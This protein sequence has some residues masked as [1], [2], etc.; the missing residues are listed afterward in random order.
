MSSNENKYINLLNKDDTSGNILFKFK[1]GKFELSKHNNNNTHD[2]SGVGLDISSNIKIYDLSFNIDDVNTDISGKIQFH[3]FKDINTTNITL[4]PSNIIELSGVKVVDIFD[5][6]DKKKGFRLGVDLSNISIKNI[7]DSSN[8]QKLTLDYSSNITNVSH[9]KELSFVV[10]KYIDPPS[11][12]QHGTTGIKFYT[13]KQFPFDGVDGSG[14]VF[15][16]SNEYIE[17]HDISYQLQNINTTNKICRAVSNTE[18]HICDISLNINKPGRT[19]SYT[20]KIPQNDI[21]E[22]GVYDISNIRSTLISKLQSYRKLDKEIYFENTFSSSP[23]SHSSIDLSLNITAYTAKTDI[24]NTNTIMNIHLHNDTTTKNFKRE[25]NHISLKQLNT[26]INNPFIDQNTFNKSIDNSTSYSNHSHKVNKNTL[27][28]QNNK[29]VFKTNSEEDND[30]FDRGAASVQKRI[31]NARWIVIEEDANKKIPDI[32]GRITPKQLYED[33][34]NKPTSSLYKN[35]HYACV[36][37]KDKD[38]KYRLGRLY[39][40]D[41]KEGVATQT[42]WFSLPIDDTDVDPTVFKKGGLI[43]KDDQFTT[44]GEWSFRTQSRNTAGYN[45]KPLYYLF[46]IK[47]PP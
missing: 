24:S 19:G 27:R 13:K 45:D 12:T 4:H 9:T 40:D 26:G 33:L 21:N 20:L 30:S 10:D 44:D 16:I 5:S 28:Y 32:Q 35:I 37:Y 42:I 14:G 36:Y 31:Q 3:D 47:N 15:G 2:F 22:T 17:L 18:A 6:F 11:I 7:R 39:N 38:N 41:D 46:G 25:F 1:N 8:I 23:S 34:K 43:V 29:F